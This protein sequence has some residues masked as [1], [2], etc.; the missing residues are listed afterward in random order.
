M[1]KRDYYEILGVSKDASVDD[2]K[3]AFRRLAKKYHPDVSKEPDAAEKFKEAQEAYAVLSDESKRRQYDQYGHAA[4]DNMNGGAGFD[5]S[6]VDLSD[7]LNDIFGGGFGGFGGF[8]NFG[9]FGG[10]GGRGNRATKGRDSVVRVELSFEEAVFGCKKTINLN[11]NETCGECNGKGGHGSKK[12]TQC[13]GTGMVSENKQTLFGSFVSQSPCPR[14]SGKGE[15]FDK[16]CNKCHGSGKVRSNKDISVTVPAGVDTGNQL[17]IRGKGEAGSNGGP[18]GDIYLEF[19]VK[20]HPIFVRDGNDIQL[21][22]PITI[23]EAALGCKKMV[24]TLDGKVKLNIPSGS[25]SGDILRLKGKGIEDVNYGRKGDM[26]V[27][28]KVIIPRKLD[29]KQKKM[30]EY[31]ADS[32]IDKDK[33]FD[34]IKKYM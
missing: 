6:D 25:Q 29:K 18:N 26:Y 9:G 19:S 15:T 12:C 1:E 3:R 27:T 10:F 4:F 2:I 28:L 5:F 13:N 33:E 11:L 21:S 16:I 32:G 31:L 8:G 30:F 7:I 14:C 17:R 23:S 34:K 22:F 24:P 20:S